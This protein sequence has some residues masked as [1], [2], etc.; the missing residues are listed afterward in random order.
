M[1]EHVKNEI[2]SILDQIL[3]KYHPIKI[4]LF[5]SA[6]LDSFNN[7]SDLDFLI[8]KDNVPH[9]GRDRSRELR[10]LLKERTLACDFLIYKQE[11]FDERFNMGDPFI[12][13]IIKEGK[14][15]YG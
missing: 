6:V 1:E 4:I 7:D 15:L 9:I 5:G 11:E 3:K 12:L 10:R 13:S 8:I 2:N 14:I